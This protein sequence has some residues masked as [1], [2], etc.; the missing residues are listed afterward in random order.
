MDRCY[1]S[2]MN[3]TLSQVAVVFSKEF[4][5]DGKPTSVS[6]KLEG[7]PNRLQE[8]VRELQSEV[9]NVGEEAEATPVQ[10]N[11]Q[12]QH[13]PYCKTSRALAV[14]S[15]GCTC[16]SIRQLREA[17]SESDRA[18]KYAVA[19]L[20]SLV[21]SCEPLTTLMGVLSQIDNWCS[22]QKNWATEK[23]EFLNQLNQLVELREKRE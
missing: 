17:A 2:N 21:P 15:V 5:F 18:Y 23:E 12:E 1:E 20:K 22:G 6:I 19:L 8:I 4:T 13:D 7:D 3:E 10:L 14:G 16:G 9:V 11:V